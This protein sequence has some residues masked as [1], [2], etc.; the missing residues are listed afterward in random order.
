[1][2][3]SVGLENHPWVWS[4][5]SEPVRTF[6]EKIAL[7]KKKG[8]VGVHWHELYEHM[9]GR[10][11]LP[12]NAIFLTFD[13]GYLDNWV[14]VYPILKKYGMKGTIFVSPDFIDPAEAVRAN[15]D[16][17]AEGRCKPEE[18][19]EAGFLNWAE[20]REMESSGLI[21][22]QSH[23]MTHT[24]HF[25]GPRIV[26]FHR[27]YPTTPYPWLF[28]NTRPDRKPYYLTED[29]QSFLPW[30]Y[31]IFEH[32]KALVATRFLPD[33]KAVAHVTGEVTERGGLDFFRRPDWRQILLDRCASEFEGGLMPGT[34]ESP[35][36][37]RARIADELQRS[38]DIIGTKLGKQVDFICWPGGGNDEQVQEIARNS[39]YKSWTLS[40]SSE[41]DK[42]NRPGADPGSIKRIGTSN[43]IRVRGRRCGTG[44]ARLQVVRVLAHQGSALHMAAAK[45]YKLS[46]LA[47]SFVVRQ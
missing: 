14:Y 35:E 42:R 2:F 3:H 5:I 25:T 36:S 31:P 29:Q 45:A 43:R 47:R 15:L 9:A 8:F 27:H 33:A 19:S 26:D 17:V 11:V 4:Y 13:D 10:C 7:L 34:Y 41:Q 37:R 23:A 6:E 38:K 21:D 24:W 30:G 44:G 39:G 22:I 40:S 12:D 16:D 32:G 18:L 28:W 1:M 20:L 46:A